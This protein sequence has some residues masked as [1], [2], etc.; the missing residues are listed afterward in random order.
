VSSVFPVYKPYICSIPSFPEGVCSFLI[1]SKHPQGLEGFN[2]E[3][4]EPI[5]ASCKYYNS[6]IHAGA[7]LLPEHIRDI[8]TI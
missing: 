5:A 4:Y 6:E 8:V 3:A 1:C 7:F 2:Q